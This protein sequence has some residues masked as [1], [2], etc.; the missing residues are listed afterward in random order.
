LLGALE[1]AREDSATKGRFL[2]NMS[3][4]L[5]TPLNGI[6][7]LSEL[8]FDGVAGPVSEEQQQYLGDV[9]ARSK[10]L[11]QLV[12]EGLDLAKVETGIVDPFQTPRT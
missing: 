2:A 4:E 9:V 3:H 11:L 7:G 12:N 10:Q 5:R 8:I 6:I 1:T